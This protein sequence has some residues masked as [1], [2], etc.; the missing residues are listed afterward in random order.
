V[1]EVDMLLFADD[2]GRDYER[3]VALCLRNRHKGGDVE[4]C[5]VVDEVL[6]TLSYSRSIRKRTRA[7]KIPCT[8]V[9][10]TSYTGN[11]MSVKSM[12]AWVV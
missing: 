9:T 10:P 6:K 1:V 8:L 3:S 7:S 12:S 5:S 4:Y 11:V 2:K